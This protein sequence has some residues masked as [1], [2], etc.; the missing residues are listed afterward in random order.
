MCAFKEMGLS[1]LCF[2]SVF[3]FLFFAFKS[4]SQ[5]RAS[6]LGNS[7]P[8]RPPAQRLHTEKPSSS[9]LSRVAGLNQP[10]PTPGSVLG[11][12]IQMEG[13]LSG[14]EVGAPGLGRLP[15]EGGARRT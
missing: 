11:P 3:A 14:A 7:E 5:E 1:F 13:L 4:D 15:G 6:S 12:N 9:F 8:S 2:V 10:P